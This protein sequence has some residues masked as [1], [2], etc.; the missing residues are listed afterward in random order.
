[1]SDYFA[2]LLSGWAIGAVAM[3]FYFH[4]VGLIKTKAQYTADRLGNE[5]E[6]DQCPVC[7][8]YCTGNGGNE[9]ID[10]PSLIAVGEGEAK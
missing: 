9:C 5:S 7:G 4:K 1:M 3:W 10:K 6:N 8:F 2:G